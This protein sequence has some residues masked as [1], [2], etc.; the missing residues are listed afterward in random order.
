MTV[1][2]KHQI[3]KK[4]GA[5]EKYIIPTEMY[6]KRKQII[7]NRPLTYYEAIIGKHIM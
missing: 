7:N 5:M 3:V 1:F 4:P 6:V 2:I